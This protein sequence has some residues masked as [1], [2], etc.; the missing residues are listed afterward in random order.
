MYY[1]TYFGHINQLQIAL[2]I[3]ALCILFDNGTIE[4]H[5]NYPKPQGYNL[6][7]PWQYKISTVNCLLSLANN[8]DT[9]LL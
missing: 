5:L 8:F 7:Q 4:L 1:E 9:K 6:E 2:Q 3:S